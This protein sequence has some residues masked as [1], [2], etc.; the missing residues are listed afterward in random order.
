MK[1]REQYQLTETRFISQLKKLEKIMKQIAISRIQKKIPEVLSAIQSGDAISI[2]FKG[3]EVAKLVPPDFGMVT[4]RKKL[5][6]I[7]KTAFVGDV[8]SSIDEEWEAMK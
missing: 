5:E 3:R 4:A 2:T 1:R 7:R 8:L 6:Q